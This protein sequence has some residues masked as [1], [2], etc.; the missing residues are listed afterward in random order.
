MNRATVKE[1]FRYTFGHAA[2]NY[3]VDV[4]AGAPCEWHNANQ[5]WYVSPAY[6]TNGFIRH[7]ATHY[8]IRVAANNI[9]RSN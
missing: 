1:P 4:P 9:I 7:D 8:G 2:G 6:F 5:E 3:S